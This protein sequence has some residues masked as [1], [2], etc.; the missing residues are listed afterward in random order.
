MASV[1]VRGGLLL[2]AGG[3]LFAGVERRMMRPPRAAPAA[4]GPGAAVVSRPPLP[5]TKLAAD[6]EQRF[7]TERHDPPA[8]LLRAESSFRGAFAGAQ[9]A[10]L[11]RIECRGHTCRA[12]VRFASE[13]RD[14]EFTR[15]IFV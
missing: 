14:A 7:Q 5:A 12:E 8:N 9:G 4:L 1:G 15:R 2:V 3:L 6:L 10:S 13:A 11:E